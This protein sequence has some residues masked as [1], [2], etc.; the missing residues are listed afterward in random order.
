MTFSVEIKGL[1]IVIGQMLGAR[2]ALW[3]EGQIGDSVLTWSSNAC[4]VYEDGVECEDEAAE[5]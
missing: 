1:S 4:V 2:L 3:G 5:P